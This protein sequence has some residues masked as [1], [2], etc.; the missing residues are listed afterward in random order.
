MQTP[1]DT[2][3]YDLF[4]KQVLL[5]AG[6]SATMADAILASRWPIVGTQAVIE[7]MRSPGLKATVDGLFDYIDYMGIGDED[8]E[9]I[10]WD[11][12]TFDDCMRWLLASGRG[13]L[14]HN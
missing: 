2:A 6:M 9:Q 7:E 11:P 8:L 10:S 5:D 1:L 4:L 12:A 13:R 3:A 14:T